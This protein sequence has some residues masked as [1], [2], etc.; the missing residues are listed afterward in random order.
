MGTKTSY[1]SG[2][3]LAV[4]P[5]CSSLSRTMVKDSKLRWRWGGDRTDFSFSLYVLLSLPY[6]MS[7]LPAILV[8]GICLIIFLRPLVNG[9]STLFPLCGDRSSD[10][11]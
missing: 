10:T 5:M 7:L 3:V 4:L 11:G 6:F 2:Q 9:P 8:D 1:F